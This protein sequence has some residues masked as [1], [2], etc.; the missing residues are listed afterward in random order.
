M[1]RI[2][3]RELLTGV[4]YLRAYLACN[5]VMKQA[6]ESM[7]AV[8]DSP[9]S[10]EQD[11]MLAYHTIDGILKMEE[12][13]ARDTFLLTDDD[14]GFGDRETDS[15]E[16]SAAPTATT[17]G[18]RIRKLMEEKGITQ[19]QLAERMGVS[20]PAVNKLITKTM[21]P[22]EETAKRMLDAM[23]ITPEE[24]NDILRHIRK[25]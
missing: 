6:V 13:A 1:K 18:D 15:Q 20:Q 2:D 3:Y 4:G 5:F 10:D 8:I 22:K 19:A 25:K 9:E 16:E 11:K 12:H 24:V 7:I 14:P 23:K 17:F 21:K